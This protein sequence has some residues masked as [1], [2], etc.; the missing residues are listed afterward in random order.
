[1]TFCALLVLVAGV[2]VLRDDVNTV[3]P[4]EWRYQQFTVGPQLRPM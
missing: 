1:M 3:P 2:T 4:G